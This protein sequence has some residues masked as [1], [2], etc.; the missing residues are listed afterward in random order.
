M[1]APTDTPQPEITPPHVWWSPFVGLLVTVQGGRARLLDLTAH[2]PVS[3]PEDAVQ[4][5]AVGV[6]HSA[7][8]DGAAFV[9]RQRALHTRTDDDPWCSC[10]I[11][12]CGMRV[13]LDHL[14]HTEALIRGIRD[15]LFEGGQNAQ[16]RWSKAIQLLEQA[17]RL[18]DDTCPSPIRLY[19][20]GGEVR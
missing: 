1:T 18:R 11:G 10:G 9:A 7:F 15:A 14:D 12:H 19:R 4:L 3:L 13:V 6:P 2:D 20:G 5:V 17:D 8:P 16:S